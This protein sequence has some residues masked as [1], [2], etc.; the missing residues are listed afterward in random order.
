MFSLTWHLQNWPVFILQRTFKSYNYDLPF[1]TFLNDR[2][3]RISVTNLHTMISLFV[4]KKKKKTK[5][6]R[7]YPLKAIMRGISSHTNFRLPSAIVLF[8][9]TANKEIV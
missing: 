5:K 8:L 2:N 7:N 3:I 1:N 6:R 4:S 9:I